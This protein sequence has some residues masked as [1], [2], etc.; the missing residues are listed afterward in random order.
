MDGLDITHMT[1]T[2][3]L[4]KERPVLARLEFRA[5]NDWISAAKIVQGSMTLRRLTKGS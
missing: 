1:D 4:L 3:N 2:V 5:R